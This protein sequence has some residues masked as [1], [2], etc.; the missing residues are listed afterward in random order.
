M[1]LEL[2]FSNSL[3]YTTTGFGRVRTVPL[4]T[5]SM[6][7]VW[8]RVVHYHLDGRWLLESTD[9]IDGNE[10]VLRNHRFLRKLWPWYS[11]LSLK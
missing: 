10:H 6:E 9:Q 8:G 1:K 7:R 4:Q 11:N 3:L 2:N 5:H